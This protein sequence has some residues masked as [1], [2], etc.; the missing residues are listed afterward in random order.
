MG[1]VAMG[2]FDSRQF[3]RQKD[4]RLI[5]AEELLERRNIVDRREAQQRGSRP[6]RDEAIRRAEL[7][8]EWMPVAQPFGCVAQGNLCLL[9]HDTFRKLRKGAVRFAFLRCTS[10]AAKAS[11]KVA[12]RQIKTLH[13]TKLVPKL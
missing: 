11:S 5:I 12:K 7:L 4:A 1:R 2:G 6:E 13:G 9:D 3:Q 10:G 8:G